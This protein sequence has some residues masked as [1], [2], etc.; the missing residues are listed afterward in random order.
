MAVHFE[1]QVQ[2][3]IFTFVRLVFLHSDVV[4]VH[5][6]PVQPMPSHLTHTYVVSIYFEWF[7]FIVKFLT[8]FLQRYISICS[9]LSSHDRKHLIRC[10]ADLLLF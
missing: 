2:V 7:T 8:Y 9:S 10:M 3:L 6:N 1:L 4:H 5:V